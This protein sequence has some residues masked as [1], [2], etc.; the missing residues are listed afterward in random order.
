MAIKDR[1]SGN[2]AVAYAM[3][4]INPDVMGLFPSRL[5]RRFRYFSRYIA[6]GEV[7]AEFVAVESNTLRVHLYRHRPRNSHITA[8]FLSRTGS[9]VGR[10]LYNSISRLP[11]TMA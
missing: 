2:E 10:P 7:E 6:D 8:T 4:Q 9:D 1:M 5:P 11:I 3:K